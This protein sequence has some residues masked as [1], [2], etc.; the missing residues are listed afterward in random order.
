[1]VRERW[2]VRGQVSAAYARGMVLGL[3]YLHARGVAHGDIKP[4]YRPLVFFR[5]E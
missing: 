5:M 4:G 1:M 2:G 3:E